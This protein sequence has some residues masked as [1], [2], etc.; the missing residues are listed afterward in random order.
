MLVKIWTEALLFLLCGTIVAYFHAYMHEKNFH[1]YRNLWGKFRRLHWGNKLAAIL[2]VGLLVAYAGV[3]PDGGNGGGGGDGGGGTNQLQMVVY[4]G[5]L[6]NVA[7]V[8]MLPIASTN[9]QLGTHTALEIGNIGTGNNFTLAT[10]IT[11]TNTTRTITA[12]DIARGFIQTRIGTGEEFDFVPPQN[13]TIVSDWH[14]FGAATD[15]IYVA[16]TNWAFQVATNEVDRLRVYSFGKIQPYIADGAGA[17][18]T[19][20]WFAPFM[21][22]LGIA[23]VSHWD[24][25]LESDRPSQVWYAITPENSLVITWQNALLDRDTD[26]SLSFQVELFTDGRF[27]FRY[28]LSRLNVDAVTNILA[29]ASFAGNAWTTNSLPTN[30]TS[31]AF[32]P[33]TEADAYDQDPDNDGLLTIDE[34]FFYN[35]DPHNAD[36]DYDGLNDG[37][38]LLVYGTDPLNPHSVSADYLDGVAAKLGELNPFDY[39]EGSTNTVLEH[40]FYS[41]TTNGVIVYPQSSV[42]TAVLEVGVSGTG[43]GRLV[44]GDSVVPLVAPPQMRSGAVTN[45]LLLAVGRGVRK[46]VWFTKPDGLDVALR[47]D[48]LLIGSLPTFYWPHGW[49]A[50]PHKEAT[51]PCIH[52]FNSRGRVVSLVH[53]EEFP[54]LTATWSSEAQGVAITNVPPVS[55]EIHGSFPKSQERSI[56]YTMSHPDYICGVTNYEQTLRF[57]PKHVDEPENGSGGG[58]D[59]EEPEYWSCDCAAGGN[60]SCCSGEWCHCSCWNCP[61]NANQ[62]PT[63]GGD[64]SDAEESFTNIV[65]GTQQALADVFYLYRANTKAKHL[66]VPSGTPVECC[67]CPEHRHTNYV[68]K[69]AYTSRVAVDYSDGSGEFK[70]SHVPCDVTLSGVSPSRDFGDSAVVFVTNG[71][72]H[73]RH[74]CTVLGVRFES[75]YNRPPLLEYNQ[76]SPSFGYPITVCTNIGEAATIVLRTDV[77]LTN[78]VVKLS[79]LNATGDFQVWLPGWEDNNAVYHAPE[80]LLSS[81][82]RTERYFTIRQWRGIMQRYGWYNGRR[83]LAVKVLSSSQGHCDL[84]FEY[85]ASSGSGRVHDYAQQRVTSVNPPLLPDYNRDG[86]INAVDVSLWLSG[87]LAY[88]WKNDDKWRGDDAFETHVLANSSN[89]VVDG[90]NDLVNFLPVAVDVSPFVENWGVGGVEYRIETE[91]EALRNAKLALADIQWP[92]IGDAALGGD[93]DIHGNALQEA[94][95]GSLGASTNLPSSFVSLAQSGRS[96]LFMEFPETARSNSISLNVY[97]KSDNALLFSSSLKL[98]VGEVAKMIGWENLRSVAGGTDGVQTQLNT[99]D[100]PANAHEPGNVVFVHGYNMAEDA[101]APCWA[102]NVFKKL[103]WS[104]LDRGFVAVQ[105]RGNEGQYYQVGY[106]WVSPNYYGNVQNAFATASALKTAMDGVQSPK[107]FIAHS[108]GNM[109]VSAAIQDYEMPY[110]RYFMLNAAVAMEAYDPTSGISQESHDNMTPVAWTNYVDTVRATHWFE[111]FPEGDGRRL[112]TWKGRFSNV[113]NIVN[114]YSTQEDVV[115]NGDGTPMPYG[116]PYSWYNQ[117]YRKGAWAMMLHEYEGGW[118]FNPYHDTVTGSWVGNEYVEQRQ[119][120][121]PQ[122]AASL[123]GD[124]LRQHP[125]FLDFANPEMH[126]SSNGSIV[127]SNYLY[128]AEML[129]YAIPS[130]SY[131]VGANPLPTLSAEDLNV[132][133]A[134]FTDG[135][136]DLPENGQRIQDKHRNWQHSTFVQRSYKRTHQL[137]DQLINF[138]KENF[139]E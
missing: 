122:D 8:G 86:R 90:R 82:D 24:W 52:D 124:V 41:S 42:D 81:A 38:E 63:L 114:F 132:N 61:C 110:E 107:W 3:K 57:C 9:F 104:G 95:V 56:S 129:A 128:R 2:V 47:S 16:I 55:A 62:S 49:L 125:F 123:T 97:C 77:L 46:E 85:A 67:P 5:G 48:D 139:H 6:V 119:R 37:E 17:S 40:V 134:D 11:S 109:L 93:Q 66:V 112:L 116:R 50:F 36:T 126:T 138:I 72:E 33:L 131:A 127:A 22:T 88:F 94:P 118:E 96:S 4:P 1:P 100:W 44:V 21:A 105:W 91:S 71:V 29:G 25:L 130:E 106:G 10:P 68:A 64:D 103:W 111:L 74:D 58:S 54:G 120:M 65:D 87:K 43:T 18:A 28:D 136:G 19:N 69:V 53:G 7:N 89:W 108:L 76:R 102:K 20:Y 30:I 92:G 133:M 45:T 15:R 135:Q 23:P 99:P 14:G 26:K 117:E 137:F 51:V 59:D 84:K 27:N 79:M 60:C 78:G 39:P 80:M 75:N 121:S 70:V 83:M 113:T 73:S 34:L 115:C 31:M 98:H 13:S 12:E 35:T 101:E 32:Y